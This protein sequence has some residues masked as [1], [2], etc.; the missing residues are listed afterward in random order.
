[1]TEPKFFDHRTALDLG[2]DLANALNAA[3]RLA[4]GTDDDLSETQARAAYRALLDNVADAARALETGANQSRAHDAPY[5][6]HAAHA[7][8]DAAK[9]AI[10]GGGFDFV[11]HAIRGIRLPEGDG[12]LVQEIYN[13][14]V[15]EATDGN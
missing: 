10:R 3:G 2:A 8:R 11:L 1:M 12:D 9:W 13:R 4:Y 5:I 15:A 14:A 7:C 6:A